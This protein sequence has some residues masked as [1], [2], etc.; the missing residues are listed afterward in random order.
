[1]A[2]VE[3]VVDLHTITEQNVDDKIGSVRLFTRKRYKAV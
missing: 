3:F 1:M 2:N